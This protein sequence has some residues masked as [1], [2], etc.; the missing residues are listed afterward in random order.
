MYASEP[1]ANPHRN[2]LPIY[3]CSQLKKREGNQNDAYLLVQKGSEVCLQLI[4]ARS[5]E[6]CQFQKNIE[7]HRLCRNNIRIRGFEAPKLVPRIEGLA[8][9]SEHL[10]IFVSSCATPIAHQRRAHVWM[11]LK[12]FFGRPCFSGIDWWLRQ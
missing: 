2:V 5:I 10:E 8:Y 1:I 6:R 3:M 11:S 12:G 7:M 4:V 9:A